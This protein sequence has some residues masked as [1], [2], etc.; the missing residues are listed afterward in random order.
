M[1]VEFKQVLR[2]TDHDSDLD[3]LKDYAG[4]YNHLNK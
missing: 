3:R 4:D 1:E 2:G